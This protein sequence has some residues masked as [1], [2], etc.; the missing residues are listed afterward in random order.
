[1]ADSLKPARVTSVEIEWGK[2][3]VTLP[4]DQKSLAIGKWA[5]NIRLAGELTGYQIELK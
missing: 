2:A 4:E 1:V 3:Y 5:S